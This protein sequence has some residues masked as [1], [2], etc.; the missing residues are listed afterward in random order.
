MVELQVLLGETGFDLETL[1]ARDLDT[2]TLPTRIGRSLARFL[3][4]RFSDQSRRQ[5][6]FLRAR[7]RD[8]F[9]WR[10]PE[11]LFAD[12]EYFRYARYSWMEAGINDVIQC[13]GWW[14]APEQLASGEWVRPLRGLEGLLPGG[15]AHLRAEA[16]ASRLR[17]RLRG[18]VGDAT[19]ETG[20]RV[21]VATREDVNALLAHLRRTVP[22]GVWT[23]VEVPL[24]RPLVAGEV[25][26]ANVAVTVG[27]AALVHRMALV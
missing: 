14:D 18:A 17:V 13:E 24:S 20:I 5:H 12:G 22:G 8:V 19:G 11:M 3:L 27:Q 9:R 4:R 7:R 1:I 21:A 6:L 23:D 2:P 15:S 10:F 26:I 25:V 16:G